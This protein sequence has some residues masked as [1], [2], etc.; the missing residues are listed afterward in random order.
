M[1]ATIFTFYDTLLPSWLDFPPA[2][3]P[4]RQKINFLFKSFVH[5]A[6][7]IPQLA[8]NV[9]IA[10]TSKRFFKMLLVVGIP[11]LL[12]EVYGSLHAMDHITCPAVFLRNPSLCILLRMCLWH[13]V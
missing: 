3:I 11:M 12:A 1:R 5:F 13:F 9:L 4:T 6:E 2:C 7:S 8:Q 10:Y